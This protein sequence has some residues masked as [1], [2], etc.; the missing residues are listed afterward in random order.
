MSKKKKTN[1][2]VSEGYELIGVDVVA[3]EQSEQINLIMPIEEVTEV[4]EVVEESPKIKALRDFVELWDG[5][6]Q[7][8]YMTDEQ[9]RKV[10]KMWQIVTGRTDYYTNCSVCTINHIKVLKKHCK[11]NGIEVSK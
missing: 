3:P 10:H 7:H 11:E 9:A 1:D 8:I 5:M 2:K 4:Q 6:N